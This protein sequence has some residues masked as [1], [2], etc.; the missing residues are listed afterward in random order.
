MA[1]RERKNNISDNAS[2]EVARKIKS[3]TIMPALSPNISIMPSV[4]IHTD[5]ILKFTKTGKFVMQIGKGAQKKTNA[6]TKNLWEPAD[7]FVYPKTNELFVADGY[8][9]APSLVD[10][11]RY[12]DLALLAH[13]FFGRCKRF[14]ERRAGE[15]P[16]GIFH[17][18]RG[19]FS[20]TN[21]VMVEPP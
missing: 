12:V 9:S 1:P 20:E 18:R 17:K 21:S 5:Q 7:V 4:M 6:D 10:M 15:D 3:A 11:T 13:D 8:G 19:G 16:L 2:V 14:D